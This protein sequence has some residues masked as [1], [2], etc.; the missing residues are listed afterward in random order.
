MTFWGEGF[1]YDAHQSKGDIFIALA[2]VVSIFDL[3]TLLVVYLLTGSDIV[4]VVV[5]SVVLFV[6]FVSTV[7]LIHQ[8]YRRLRL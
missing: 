7:T 1:D 5:L 8:R 2:G 4:A 3:L 6:F